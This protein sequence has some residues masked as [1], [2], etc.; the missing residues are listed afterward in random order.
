LL[1]LSYAA[2]AWWM[3]DLIH[4]LCFAIHVRRIVVEV[5]YL[6]PSLTSMGKCCSVCL[7]SF[8]IIGNIFVWLSMHAPSIVSE[9]LL[10]VFQQSALLPSL[11]SYP[12]QLSL[13]S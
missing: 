8:I 13:L 4:G 5:N 2:V 10:H 12:Q 11:Q 3:P 7:G 1:C 6:R 9:E